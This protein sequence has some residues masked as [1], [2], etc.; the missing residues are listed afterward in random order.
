M[1]YVFS[2]DTSSVRPDYAQIAQSGATIALNF[3]DKNLR[4]EM[5]RARDAGAKVAIWIPAHNDQDPV[6]YGQQMASI[7]QYLKPDAILPNIEAQGKV[8]RGGDVWSDRMM[9]EFTKYVPAGSIPL[10]VVTEPGEK[11]FNYKPYLNFGGGVVNEAFTGDMTHWDPDKARQNL[12]DAGVPP[13]RINMLLAPGQKPG[14]NTGQFSAYTW[15]DMKPEQQAAFLQ[16]YAKAAGA[17]FK[18]TTGYTPPTTA[19]GPGAPAP[20]RPAG[21]DWRQM[22]P[23]QIR[24]LWAGRPYANPRGLQATQVEPAT[25]PTTA[26][27]PGQMEDYGVNM[28][29]TQTP[30]GVGARAIL[31]QVPP[32]GT[33]NP[34]TSTVG[35]PANQLPEPGAGGRTPTN[36]GRVPDR[37]DPRA[38]AYAKFRL[39]QDGIIV[40]PGEDAAAMWREYSAQRAGYRDRAL[41]AGPEPIDTLTPNPPRPAPTPT[42]AIQNIVATARSRAATPS[43][44]ITPTPR[45]PAATPPPTARTPMSITELIAAA[46]ARIPQ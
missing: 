19:Q 40:K 24:A 23:D 37:Y 34:Q 35:Q 3:E 11:D 26:V 17:G 4:E 27:G 9:Q 16:D 31:A 20:E 1:A 39:K 13:D 22:T 38:Q 33:T 10:S 18:S 28:T 43:P 45:V 42:P 5:Q 36:V 32:P 12:I 8:S 2:R 29:P 21:K 44:A 41:A 46:R 14:A 30:A 6:R 15:D 25:G 7:V